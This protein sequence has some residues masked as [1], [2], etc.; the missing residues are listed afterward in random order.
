MLT[1]IQGPAGS[2]KSAVA[3]DL[4]S[5]GELEVLFDTTAIWAALSGAV[6]GPD[7]RFPPRSDDDPSLATALYLQA[8]GARFALE[9][10]G[11]GR[12]DHKPTRPRGALVGD[13]ASGRAR[14]QHP[15]SRSR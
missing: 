2:G 7:G 9:Q 15:R 13:R 4:L 3:A 5:A 10:W 8:V 12:S 6:R 14:D 11:A 1:L